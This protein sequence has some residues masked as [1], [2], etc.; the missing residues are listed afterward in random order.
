MFKLNIII[1]ILFSTVFMGVI[2]GQEWPKIYGNSISVIIRDIKESYDYGYKL[3][4]YNYKNNGSPQYGMLTKVDINGEILW[5]KKFGDGNYMVGLINSS[6]TSDNGIIISG[7]ISK[8]NQSGKLDPF[9]IKLNFCGEVEWCQVLLSPEDN[10]GMDIIQLNDGSYIGL[11]K[12]YGGDYENVRISLVKLDTLGQPVWIKNLAQEDPLIHNEE[13]YH[14][15]HT[16]DDNCI[17]SGH[18]FYPNSRPFWIKTDLSGEQIWDL[19]WSVGSGSADQIIES[20]NGTFYVAGGII[21]SGRPMTPTLFKFDNNGN[22]LY[23]K[24]LLGDTIVGGGAK[25]LCFYNDSTL[26]TGFNWSNVPYPVD[27]GYSE[28]I[29][30][31]TLGNIKKRKL[32]LDENKPPTNII[33]TFDDKILVSGNYV[34]DDNWDIYLWKLNSELEDDTLYTQSYNYD[35]LCPYS[36]TSDTIDLDCGLYVSIDEIPLKEEYDKVLKVFPNPAGEIVNC[37][38]SIVDFQFEL[39]IEIYDVFGRKMEDVELL[40]GQDHLQINVSTYPAGLYVA[41]LR[42]DGKILGREKFVVVK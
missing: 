2:H 12:Y 20:N 29:M 34:V 24:F 21:S 4:G 32:L 41:V 18:C 8:Y 39:V 16:S 1:A 7:A 36:I 25:P 10:Y 31:D 17:V 23:H 30:I 22:Q 19:K 42:S 38:L 26:L 15:I 9:F 37:Q 11:L 13:G 3:I 6:L 35:S 28:I 40:Q 14:L 27:I 5:E 33:N